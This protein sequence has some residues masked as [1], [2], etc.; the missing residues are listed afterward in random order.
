MRCPVLT[1]TTTSYL[2]IRY[3][4]SGTDVA[5][6]ATSEAGFKRRRRHFRASDSSVRC[7]TDPENPGCHV[8]GRRFTT[9][10]RPVLTATTS[11]RARYAMSDTDR[12]VWWYQGQQKAG[13]HAHAR[14][15]RDGHSQGPLSAYVMSG[16]H[17]ANGTLLPA[18]AS[19]TQCPEKNESVC[20]PP[21]P[22]RGRCSAVLSLITWGSQRQLARGTEPGH[23]GV[24]RSAGV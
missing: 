2:N 10:R 13:A 12:G 4:M 7:K 16:T 6:H 8:T 1:Q 18:Y 9:V 22:P 23:V 20:K 19:A 15:A 24:A 11:Q 21:L 3:A 17:I 5:W 14:Q